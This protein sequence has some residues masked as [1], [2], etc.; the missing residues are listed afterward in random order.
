MTDLRAMTTCIGIVLSESDNV[1]MVEIGIEA[2][3]KKHSRHGIIVAQMYSQECLYSVYTSG[4]IEFW[5]SALITH[6]SDVT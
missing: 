6:E 5:V 4:S 3:W 2:G 1:G